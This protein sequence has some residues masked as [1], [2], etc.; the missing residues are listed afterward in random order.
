MLYLLAHIKWVFSSWHLVFR[1]ARQQVVCCCNAFSAHACE[2]VFLVFW[3]SF[4]E[5]LSFSTQ[6]SVRR[7]VSEHCARELDLNTE[8]REHNWSLSS[9]RWTGLLRGDC[10]IPS[11]S[12]VAADLWKVFKSVCVIG[13]QTCAR[14]DVRLGI[15]NDRD[16]YSFVIG[17]HG[18]EH[19]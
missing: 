14:I 6:S 17:S 5:G 18:W 15:S 16:D 9:A 11:D 1:S 12:K 19:V 3:S 13:F 10:T 8:T 7:D 4:V 2:W